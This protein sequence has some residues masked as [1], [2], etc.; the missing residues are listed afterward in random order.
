MTLYFKSFRIDD[1]IILGQTDYDAVAL[2]F[3]TN[4]YK[5]MFRRFYL[6]LI[7]RCEVCFRSKCVLLEH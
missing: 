3:L 7:E 4:F 1:A 2:L 6:Y 5:T